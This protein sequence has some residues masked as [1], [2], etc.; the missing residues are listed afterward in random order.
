MILLNCLI[1]H[2]LFHIELKE[3]KTQFFTLILKY[4]FLTPILYNFYFYLFALHLSLLKLTFDS[5]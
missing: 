3:N 5:L 1:N 2:K 4:I